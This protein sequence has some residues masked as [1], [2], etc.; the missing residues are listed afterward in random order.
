MKS[1]VA[2][3]REPNGTQLRHVAI[4]KSIHLTT[5]KVVSCY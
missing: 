3:G 5:T 4:P 1:Q 2:L